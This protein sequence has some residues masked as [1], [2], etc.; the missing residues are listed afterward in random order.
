MLEKK[1]G[2]G[3]G[4]RVWETWRKGKVIEQISRPKLRKILGLASCFMVLT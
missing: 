1:P 4:R 3:L 2:A